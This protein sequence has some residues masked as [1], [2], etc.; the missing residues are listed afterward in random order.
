MKNSNRG[1]QL[2]DEHLS[3]GTGLGF[4]AVNLKR[5]DGGRQRVSP[6]II[7]RLEHNETA[8]TGCRLR[9]RVA[10]DN[11]CLTPSCASYTSPRVWSVKRGKRSWSL[12]R[13]IEY[14][15]AFV[16]SFRALDFQAHENN[17]CYNGNKNSFA[18]I[19]CKINPSDPLSIFLID[20]LTQLWTRC[21]F[22]KDLQPMA[23]QSTPSPASSPSSSH[24]H[25]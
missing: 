12:V 1:E 22:P 25:F 19:V 16:T 4:L 15:E 18:H 11:A 2:Y 8:L 17:P 6:A 7:L 20:L 13:Q 3:T 9:A 24:S 14:M 21:A 23:P 10:S 5:L